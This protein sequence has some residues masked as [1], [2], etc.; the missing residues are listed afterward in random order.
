MAKTYDIKKAM[1]WFKIINIA[2]DI[3]SKYGLEYGDWAGYEFAE[4][5]ERELLMERF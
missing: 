1:L 3:F 4:N 5:K 2:F